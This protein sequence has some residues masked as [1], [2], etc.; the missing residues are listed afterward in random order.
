MLPET[1]INFFLLAINLFTPSNTITKE[2]MCRKEN[3]C[4]DT[5]SVSDLLETG[6]VFQSLTTINKTY[7]NQITERYIFF[8]FRYV[9]TCTYLSY[10][11]LL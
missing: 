2:Q 1:F 10:K 9:A 3:I 7:R 6:G 8:R 11:L 5:I 4:V